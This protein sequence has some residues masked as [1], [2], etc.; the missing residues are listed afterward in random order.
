M[1]H[2]A[3]NSSPN[4]LAVVGWMTKNVVATARYFTIAAR[5]YGLNSNFSSDACACFGR[6]CQMGREAPADVPV[7]AEFSRKA[8]DSGSADGAN[9]FG[10]CL[11][12][13]DGV[14]A[15]VDSTICYYRK[16]ASQSRSAGLYH[17]G[18]CVEYG[19]GIERAFVPAA[20]YY[21]KPAEMNSSSAQ[22]GFAIC[23][24][25]GVRGALF[26]MLTPSGQC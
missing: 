4:R 19:R 10:C 2:L 5:N 22:N 13:S 3:A 7:A 21:R 18:R 25:W 9:S 26:Q 8:A 24:E 6:C 20:Q 1:P 12:R 14:E 16:A 17:C 23:L 15:D 11:K